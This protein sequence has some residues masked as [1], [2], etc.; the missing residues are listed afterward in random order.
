M[1]KVSLR[2]EKDGKDDS[3]HALTPGK[4]TPTNGEVLMRGLLKHV[5]GLKVSTVISE[6]TDS[7]PSPPPGSQPEHS[8]LTPGNQTTGLHSK[9]PQ[10][11][12][13]YWEKQRRDAQAQTQVQ[14]E[15][16]K[17]RNRE[18]KKRE[19]R[20]EERSTTTPSPPPSPPRSPSPSPGSE[21]CTSDE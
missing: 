11:N 3:A 8:E 19:E 4:K 9:R 5:S 21:R 18:E 1:K 7:L 13:V 16:L 20:R 2:Q 17:A 12:Q 14:R 15:W 10:K 6:K